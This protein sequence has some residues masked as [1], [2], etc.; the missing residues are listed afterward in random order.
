MGF[1]DKFKK[2]GGDDF[3]DL[4]DLGDFGLD[5][6]AQGGG[7]DG[8]GFDD[9]GGELGPMP[10]MDSPGALEQ[11]PGSRAREEV[12]PTQTSTDMGNQFGLTPPEQ[13]PAAY[14]SQQQMPGAVSMQPPA[15]QQ[16]QAYPPQQQMQSSAQVAPAQQMQQSMMHNP[17]F[18]EF[19][20]DI[21]IIHAKL[22]AI[23][24]SLDSVNQ[25]LAT[26]ERMATP[27]NKQR[28]TW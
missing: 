17:D 15:Q 5:N 8:G 14:S 11:H 24:S 26:L 6:D 3:G 9:L 27:N 13:T 16:T 12:L 20:K 18:N 22:D 19:M 21:E 2:K 1:L 10:G 4:S 28:Y 7:L 25:R 23:K